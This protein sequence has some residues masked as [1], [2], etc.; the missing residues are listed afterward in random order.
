MKNKKLAL[1]AAAAALTLLSAQGA[2]AQ[3]KYDTG[4]SDTEIRIGNVEAYS[5]PA[6][7]Y[8][9]IG[10]TEEAYFKMDIL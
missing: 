10:K 9:V 1:L 3:K 4:A 6:S 2:Q 8:G 7:A 5:G